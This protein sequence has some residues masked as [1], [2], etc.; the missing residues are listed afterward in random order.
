MDIVRAWWGLTTTS[1]ATAARLGGTMARAGTE[2]VRTVAALPL[3]VT[4]EAL[5]AWRTTTARYLRTLLDIPDE[6]ANGHLPAHAVDAVMVVRTLMASTDG[7]DPDDAA[8]VRD[9][10]RQL[11]DRSA[12]VADDPGEPAFLDIV[13]Q[14]TPDEARMV[15]YLA[16]NGAVAALDL[17]AHPVVG[18]HQR[19][20]LRH[21]TMLAERA[22]CARPD[23]SEVYLQNLARLGLLEVVDDPIED[24][25][26]Y[27]LIEGTPA[28]AAATRAGRGDRSVRLR[29]RRGSIV[30]TP[31]GRRFVALCLGE[32]ATTTE[33][34]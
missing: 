12:D 32:D 28:Y 3:P 33:G 34:P 30:L 24:E 11:L 7:T 21:Q 10:F 1:A 2:V 18:R 15:R 27:Q 14:L 13:A 20:V 4:P 23:R 6:I 29:G 16:A 26:E 31:L 8:L 22:G 19:V 25:T 5:D 17:V 9:R